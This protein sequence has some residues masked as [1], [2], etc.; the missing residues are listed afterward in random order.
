MKLPDNIQ[1]VVS[2]PPHILKYR[3]NRRPNPP[4]GA[5]KGVARVEGY[6]I[7]DTKFVCI[8]TTCRCSGY[9]AVRFRTRPDWFGSGMS[10]CYICNPYKLK[11]VHKPKPKTTIK[12]WG[13]I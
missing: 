8:V 12:G 4:V 7:T 11:E 2:I 10:R 3:Y 5:E 9:T 6:G 13:I 1:W